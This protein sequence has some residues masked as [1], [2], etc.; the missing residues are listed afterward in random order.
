M[1][2]KKG[3][4]LWLAFGLS[5]I[6]YLAIAYNI[7]RPETIKLLSVYGIVFLSYLYLAAQRSHLSIK[8][9]I[10]IGILF[11]LI[12]LFALPEL[13]DDFYRFIWDGR[14]WF[15]GIN[16][17]AEL[18][19]YYIKNPELAPLGINQELFRL[20]NSP[21]HYT[22]YPPIP[23]FINWIAAWLASDSIWLSA[24]I[25]RL[26]HIIA[27]IGTLILLPKVLGGFHID[28]RNIIW[29]AL[30]PLIIIELVGN[31]HH[32]A[33]MVFFMVLFL[34]NFQQHK[35]IGGAFA[36]AMAVAAKLLPFMFLPFILLK[37]NGKQNLKFIA[38]FGLSLGLVFF[39]LL[40]E[41]FFRGIENSLLLYYQHFEFNAGFYYLFREI[42]FWVKGY[43]MIELIGKIFAFGVTLSILIISVIAYLRKWKT[44]DTYLLISSIFAL[45]SLILHPWYI[46]LVI[47]FG[48]MTRYKFGILWSLL[49]MGTYAGYSA[50]GFEEVMGIVTIE[51]IA[52]TLMVIYEIKSV[53][54]IKPM[55]D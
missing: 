38:V 55:Q 51:F 35:T 20:L 9:I 42:G 22:V 3:F 23:Q 43:N 40:D 31:L 1:P 47:L 15:N 24:V 16:P 44:T 50:N 34:V 5:I 13:S 17:F 14:L 32:E 48:T 19:T 18:P 25:M 21:T 33:L 26:A 8:T 45:F 10:G 28:K 27:E 39:P 49:I 46:S 6:G 7:Q 2:N 41:S 29:Y 4:L 12:F 52:I 36:L 54:K 37:M 11:R 53:S 30:N